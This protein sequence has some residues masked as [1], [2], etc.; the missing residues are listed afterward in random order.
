MTKPC[1]T[2]GAEIHAPASRCPRAAASGR[3]P[4]AARD[5]SVIG[6]KVGEY[7]IQAFLGEGGMGVV[8][9]GIQPLIG[10]PVAIKVL[11]QEVAK[12]QGGA[13]QLLR[14]ARAANAIRHPGIIDIFS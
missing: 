12:A 7:E 3:D 14:E 9:R 6:L 10:K 1:P 4:A 5:D 8:Y 11:R 13:E 2:C